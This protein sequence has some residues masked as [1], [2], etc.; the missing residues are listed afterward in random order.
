MLSLLKL[1]GRWLFR[2]LFSVEYY[3]LGNVPEA[4]AVIIAGNHPSYLDPLLVMVPIRRV[5]RYMA[6]DALF[7]VPVLGQV[8]RLLGA[9]P[10]D[11]R[12]GKGESAFREA[13]R[14]LEEGNA[15]G[16]FPEGQRSE[17]GPMGELR[18]GVARLAIETGAPIVP[19]TIGGASRAWPKHRLLPKPARIIV[20]FHPPV[21][22]DPAECEARRDDREFHQE[23]M[24]T[25][26]AS[27][28]RSLAPTLRGG[29]VMERWYRQPPSHWRT[30]E[31]AP[32]FAAVVATLIAYGRQA[33]PGNLGGI[34]LPV[35][36][37]YLYLIIDLVLISPGRLAKWVRNS[38][39]V[40][41]ILVW[42]GFLTKAVGVPFGELNLLLVAAT[43]GAFFLFFYED[44]FTLQK[45]VRGL[46]VVYY[47]T[48]LL[49]QWWPE[50]RA[51]LVAVLSF[52]AIFCRWYRVIYY[53][54]TT[55]VM[56]LLL[57][58]ALLLTRAMNP[59]L[60]I[61]VALPV[62]TLWYL[63]TFVNAAYDI[64][65][66]GDVKMQKET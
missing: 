52:I 49:Q 47:F 62:V 51:E 65:Q 21:R 11:I 17:R 10:V 48:L 37:Y 33:L 12:R 13:K 31:W 53:R 18:T 60:L 64:R 35:I 23:V 56:T 5:I 59:A 42:H 29:E 57:A 14:I 22:L 15:L 61:Y 50:P 20:R 44:Y 26:A 19:V 38:M 30:Y 24:Q 45:F 4:G 1:I 25:V 58:T 34:W 43:L 54:V 2:I 3:G 7:K 66:A 36:G 40:W 6:W 46:V 63:Q 9:F 28:N 8:I 41:L 27:I 39:P 55:P 16:I 32:L